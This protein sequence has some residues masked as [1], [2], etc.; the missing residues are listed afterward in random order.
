[1]DLH[2]FAQR[3][4]DAW[5]SQN[6]ARVAAHFSP[7][8]SLSINGGAPAIGR[9]AIAAV[10]QSFMTAIPDLAL[11]FDGLR[12][13]GCRFAYHWTFTGTYAAT[14]SPVRASG[15]ESWLMSPEGLI[16]QSSGHFDAEDYARQTA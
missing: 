2:A 4:T 14:G 1:M 15:Y 13:D 11:T 12:P 9:E 10:A 6:P 5:G 3:Y 8:G 7:N 16:A